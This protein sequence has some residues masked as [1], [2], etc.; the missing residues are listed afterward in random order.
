MGKSSLNTRIKT[1][2]YSHLS[3]QRHKALPAIGNGLAAEAKVE[4]PEDTRVLSNVSRLPVTDDD[5]II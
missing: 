5:Q 2:Q 3:A 4:C 1:S